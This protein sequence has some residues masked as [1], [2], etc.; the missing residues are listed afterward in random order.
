MTLRHDQVLMWLNA[1]QEKYVIVAVGS[2]QG[3]DFKALLQAA[4][5][6][7]HATTELPPVVLDAMEAL[8]ASEV[9]TDSY[10]M[11][12]SVLTLSGFSGLRG[13]MENF[14][15][16]AMLEVDGFDESITLRVIPLDQE[17]DENDG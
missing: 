6:L 4:G 9:F 14:Q 2:G 5:T 16:R 13:R 11:G 8:D 10:R 7:Q 1:Q 15:G 3:D 12:E 17:G